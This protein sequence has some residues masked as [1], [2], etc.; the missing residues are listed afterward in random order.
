MA[1]KPSSAPFGNHHIIAWKGG[2]GIRHA[3]RLID[4]KLMDNRRGNAGR[5]HTKTHEVADAARGINGR[6]M[7]HLG[8]KLYKQIVGKK[9]FIH[10]CAFAAYDFFQGDHRRQATDRLAFEMFLGALKLASFAVK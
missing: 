2:F 5:V 4:R 9:R 3:F 6:G 8:I 10:N 7:N 1:C